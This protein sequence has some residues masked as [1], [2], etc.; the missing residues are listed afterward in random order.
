MSVAMED[1]AAIV[2][3]QG[4]IRLDDLSEPQPG[5]ALLAPREDFYEHQAPAAA[6]TL[7]VIEVSDSTIPYDTA[8]SMIDRISRRRVA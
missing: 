7:L 2:Q 5:F 3:C 8:G 1:F 6:D 4:S